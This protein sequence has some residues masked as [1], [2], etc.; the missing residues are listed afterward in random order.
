MKIPQFNDSKIVDEKGNLNA[1]WKNILI[2]LLQQLQYNL[3][4]EGYKIPMVTNAK[5]ATLNNIKSNGAL[6]YNSDTHEL[7]INKNGTFKNVLT[8]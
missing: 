8:S 3:S 7:M 4:D 6:V 5:L 1:N 2:S